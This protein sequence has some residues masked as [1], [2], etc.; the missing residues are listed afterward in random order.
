MKIRTVAGLTIAGATFLAACGGGGSTAT[1]AA[2]STGGARAH[3]SAATVGVRSTRLGDVLVDAQG[4]TLYGFTND[5]AGTSTCTGGGSLTVTS[6]SPMPG[7]SGG[8]FSL[9]LA[10]LASR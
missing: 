3:P 5:T 6:A 4:R 9:S 7:P 2:A 10:C 1:Q 8:R